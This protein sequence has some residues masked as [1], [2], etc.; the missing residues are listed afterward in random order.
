MIISKKTVSVLLMSLLMAV[1]CD[2]S[3]ESKHDS[4]RTPLHQVEVSTASRQQVSHRQLVS[5]T[6]E[7]ITSVRLYNEESGRITQLPYFEG[8]TVEKDVVVI[9]LDDALIQA[10]L[11][12]AVA[13]RQQA[14]INLKRVKKLLPKKLTSEDEMAR[15]KTAVNVT[16]AE[17]QLQRTRL[18]RS[19]V[20]APFTGVISK[21]NNE[22][23]DTVSAN[24]HILSM[25]DPTTMRVKIQI[26]ERW[27]PL[28]Q[29]GDKV[30]VRIDA[31]G[32]ELHQ[33]HISRI[34]P[35]IEPSTRKGTL[36][37]KLE[38]VPENARAGQLARVYIASQ[39]TERLVIP[40]LAVHH[41]MDG[42]YAYVVRKD[43]TGA[44]KTFKQ[45]L[46]KGSQYGKWIEII[47]GI[48]LGDQVI[49]KGFLGLRNNKKVQV[50]APH[51]TTY[52]EEKSQSIESQAIES[53][54]VE[55]E[56]AEI[57]PAEPEPVEPMPD[58][59]QAPTIELP[60][61]VSPETN[62]PVNAEPNKDAP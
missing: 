48:E 11:D 14:G 56:P 5:G 20:K 61:T 28:M 44:D 46:L 39:T 38:P 15:A 42:A 3:D 58:K 36:E 24:S 9:T 43:K 57:E 22:S 51:A 41:D 60:Q 49:V 59:R 62:I 45:K 30:E 1:A 25:I 52:D 19:Q 6:L 27:I 53:E 55:I 54:P 23:G 8:D 13:L 10:E 21:R 4:R 35:T 37:V 31:L 7:A 47:S 17:E 34:H 26:S 18:M 40:S 32:D 33:G 2:S 29:N 16:K 12:K 50:V